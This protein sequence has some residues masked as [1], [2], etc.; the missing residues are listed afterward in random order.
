MGV[1]SPNLKIT[2]SAAPSFSDDYQFILNIENTVQEEMVR[3]I[4]PNLVTFLRKELKNSSIDISTRI[5]EK[6]GEKMIYSDDEKYAEMVKKNPDLLLLRQKFNL[7]F[8][9]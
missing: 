2:L 8:G 9:D 4:K 5:V 1:D 3:T 7:D 6:S